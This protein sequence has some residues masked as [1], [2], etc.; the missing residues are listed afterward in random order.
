MESIA[1][2][3]DVSFSGA[4]PHEELKKR[5]KNAQEK[6]SAASKYDVGWRRVVRHFSPA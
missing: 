2:G 3:E 6:T 5:A 1:G 4:K